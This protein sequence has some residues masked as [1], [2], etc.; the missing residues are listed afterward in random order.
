MEKSKKNEVIKKIRGGIIVSCQAL[1]GEPLYREEGGVMPLMA[2]AA[3]RAGAVGIRANGIRDIEEIMERIAL[4]VIGIIKR[5]YGKGEAY[6]TPTMAEADQLAKTGCDIIAI[7]F[8]RQSHPGGLGAGEFFRQVRLK[9]P[10][11]LLMADCS[12]LEDA[13][14]ASK[15][16][17]DFVSTTLN[18]YVK[19]D[20]QLDGPNFELAEQIVKQVPVPLIAEGRIHTPEQARAMLELGALSVVVGGAI[21]RPMEIARRFV[22]EAKKAEIHTVFHV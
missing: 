22:D 16:G 17:A 19:G 15:E 18:G 9:Y 4:P 2:E 20:V 5:N 7:D 3:R 6:I 8:T 10:D 13:M 1:K 21:T 12:S 11:Q 14:A